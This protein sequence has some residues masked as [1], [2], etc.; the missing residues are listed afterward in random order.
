MPVTGSRYT[1]FSLSKFMYN[2]HS[3]TEVAGCNKICADVPDIDHLSARIAIIVRPPKVSTSCTDH[4]EL[5]LWQNSGSVNK[6][7]KPDIP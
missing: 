5:R 7:R 2:V 6:Q 4:L 1:I 3:D